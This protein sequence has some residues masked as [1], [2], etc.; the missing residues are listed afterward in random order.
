MIQ[1]LSASSI[2][3]VQL[4]N[5]AAGCAA[6]L[7]SADMGEDDFAL[8]EALGMTRSCRLRICKAGD[9]WIVQVRDTRIGL[10][11]SVASRLLVVL[12]TVV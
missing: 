3:P 9:P 4:T 7:H 8:L 6:R 10:A 1:D 2:S 11:A 12:D 5:L